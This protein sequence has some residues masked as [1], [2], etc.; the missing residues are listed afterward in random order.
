MISKRGFLASAAGLVCVAATQAHARDPIPMAAHERFMRLAIA[1]GAKNP[2]A[3]FGAVIVNPDSGEVLAH[4]VNDAR[5]NPLLH[6]EIACMNDYLAR[7]GNRGW[8]PLLLYVTGECCPMCMGALIWSGIGG[9]VFGS[10][11]ETIDRA[12]G[13]G[14]GI[15][16]H[17]TTIADAAPSWKGTVTGGVLA[18]ETDQLFLER[19]K[20]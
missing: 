2:F 1:E 18:A 13:G 5:A 16:I 7:H 17:A 8:E 15:N 20:N 11:I 19:R 6:A 12:F 4:G 9:V 3:P 10:S 14:G